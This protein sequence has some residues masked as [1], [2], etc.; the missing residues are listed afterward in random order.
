MSRP[1]RQPA[2]ILTSK[3]TPSYSDKKFGKYLGYMARKE[4]LESKEYLTDDEKKELKEVTTQARKLDVYGKFK[5]IGESKNDSEARKEAKFYLN[6][7]NFSELSN[8]EFGKYLGYMDRIDALASKQDEE[9][10]TV[11]ESKELQRVK[12]AASKLGDVHPTKEKVALG[13]FTRDMDTVRLQDFQKIKDRLNTAQANGS[14]MWQD[15]VS[16][17]NKFLEKIGVLN[18]ETGELNETLLR[19]ATKKMMDVFEK[20]MDP[21]LY[22]P[23]WTASIHRNTDNIHIHIA[24]VEAENQREIVKRPKMVRD[25]KTGEL[26]PTQEYVYQS[27]GR[28]PQSV[29]DEMK[30]T[31][32]NEI[33]DTRELTRDISLSRDNVKT[34][35]KDVIKIKITKDDFQKKLNEFAKHLPTSRRDWNY[36]YFEKHD[37]EGKKLLD[38]LTKELVKNDPDYKKYV[39][40]VKE[41][42]DNRQELYGVSKRDTKNYAKNKIKDITR[43][44]GNTLLHEIAQIDKKAEKFRK[45][46]N[47]LPID[48]DSK[49][50][51]KILKNMEQENQVEQRKVVRPRK[52]NLVQEKK[53]KYKKQQRQFILSQREKKRMEMMLHQQTKKEI[54]RQ[55]AQMSKETQKAMNEYERIQREV[56]RSQELGD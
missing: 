14:I 38:N 54:E 45:K 46:Y 15:V 52:R 21:P 2:I 33:L 56:Q 11:Q 6:E 40:E 44:N 29:I 43:R 19:K 34:N 8:E 53:N 35:M 36:S 7:K 51:Q 17:D 22:K 5:S 10:L 23:Y 28:R 55:K 16:F 20:K 42:Q 37:P 49:Y 12:K 1:R 24:T 13:T 31:F 9:G 3:F 30:F 18:S 25:R 41:Y 32:A 27:K 50:I 47:Y 48:K 39:K 4:A 26:V